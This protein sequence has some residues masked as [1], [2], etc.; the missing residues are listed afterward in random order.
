MKKVMIIGQILFLGF[1]VPALAKFG[2]A[3]GG[4]ELML[5]IIG[6]LLI[7]TGLLAG[8]EYLMKNGRDLFSR[9]KAFINKKI[10]IHKHPA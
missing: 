7:V 8:I 4:F 9:L 6:F 3:D 5:A 2:V 1:S 10:S